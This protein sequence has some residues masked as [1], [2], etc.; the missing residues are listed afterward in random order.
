MKTQKITHDTKTTF[1]EDNKWLTATHG[2]VM[3]ET[4][5]RNSCGSWKQIGT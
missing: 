3:M 2:I 1:F 5:H 4:T